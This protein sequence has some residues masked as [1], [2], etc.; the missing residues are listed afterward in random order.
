MHL[1]EGRTAV[2][3]AIHALDI[4]R[5]TSL[6]LEAAGFVPG[7]V[8][9]HVA[10]NL[11]VIVPAYNEAASIGDTI[12]SLLAQTTEVFEIF[13]VD[14]GSTDGTGEI[15]AALGVR[16][17]RPPQNTGSKAGAQNFALPLVATRY[18][19]AIDADTVLEPNAIEILGRSFDDPEVVAACG[20]V[21][22]R[23]VDTV[24]ERGRYIEY[25]YSFTFHKPVQDLYGKPLISSGCFSLYRTEVLADVGGWSTRT[26]AE[27]M[28]LT[29][30]FYERGHKVRF[31]PEAISYPIE[32]RTH[33]FM[34]KQ[35]RR[36][37]HGFLQNVM[38]HWRG[39]LPLR[40]L[41]TTVAVGFF[42]AIIS[43]PVTLIVLPLLAALVSPWYLL[44]YVIDIP[45]LAVPVLLGARRR[46][47]LG[48]ALVSI[49]AYFVLRLANC[50]YMLSAVIAELVL[51]RR[52]EVYEK[53]H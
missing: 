13:V 33:H 3:P 14:D 46:G 52:L 7:A 9:D 15:A 44:G 20:F 25:L 51:R 48:R 1:D 28:D 16:V 22:P 18:V 40:Y 4:D 26:M 17:L 24:W 36:W 47:E 23:H 5:A 11:T 42:D 19:M 8:S 2:V 29:W 34:G 39:I 31:V 38:L 41:R 6:S 10:S 43:P 49:P 30:T 32:P 53:G 50:W 35:L 27:D 12:R 37:S 21:L 45:M